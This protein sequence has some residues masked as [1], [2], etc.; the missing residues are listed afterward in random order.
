MTGRPLPGSHGDQPGRRLLRAIPARALAAWRDG[1]RSVRS[2]PGNAFGA[3]FVLALASGAA[4]AVWAVWDRAVEQPLPFP[5]AGELVELV[6]ESAPRG[7]PILYGREVSFLAREASSLSQLGGVQAR[8]ETL[9]REDF[10][11]SVLAGVVDPGVLDLLEV[12]PA[13]GR[14]FRPEDHAAAGSGETPAVLGDPLW[15]ALGSPPGILGAE[16]RLG[17]APLRVIGVMPPRFHFP[18]ASRDLW[19]P[20]PPRSAVGFG[21]VTFESVSAFG[22]LRPGVSPEAAAAEVTALMG[23]TGLPAALE[24]EGVRIGIRRLADRA[25]ATFRPALDLLRAGVWLLALAAAIGAAALRLS[26]GEQRR[27]ALLA[28]HALGASRLD[29]ALAALSRVVLLGSLAA[30]LGAL[31]ARALALLWLPVLELLEIRAPP[32]PAW[33]VAAKGATLAFAAAAAAECAAFRPGRRPRLPGGLVALAAAVA[34]VLAVNATL[35]SRS[36][37]GTLR[38]ANAWPGEN[39]VHLTLDFAAGNPGAESLD[40]LVERLAQLP[41]VAAAGYADVLPDEAGGGRFLRGGSLDGDDSALVVVRR[42]S[43]T[44]LATLGLPIR[45][46]RG[47]LPTDAAPAE[48]VAL[49]DEAVR[50][51]LGGGAVLDR[52]VGPESG[53]EA[54]QFRIVGVI[55]EVRAGGRAEGA[56]YTHY[57]HAA[58]VAAPRVQ[59]AVRLREPPT[60]ALLARLRRL[61]GETDPALRVLRF[62]TAEVRRAARLGVGLLTPVAASVFGVAGVLLGVIGILAQIASDLARKRSE[63]AVRAALGAPE[64]S[65][66]L[67]A[68]HG[69]AGG[70]LLGCLLGLAAAAPLARLLASRLEWVE[71]GGA[72]L[73]LAPFAVCLAASLLGCLVGALLAR[74]ELAPGPARFLT[75]GVDS[76]LSAV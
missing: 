50:R 15:R 31:L 27:G 29:E 25:T 35:L 6:A 11:R 52:I 66:A 20:A 40:L 21:F 33:P 9:A 63:L 39:L 73:Y 2:A 24:R 69:A 65:L 45:D 16:L 37:L 14:L 59:V 53:L 49:A 44:L 48:R 75:R 57:S 26:L 28:R 54:E 8:R 43:P 47:L 72:L 1:F 10:A 64:H 36:A 22:R 23:R 71:P 17:A 51:R 60:E 62:E 38:G 19:L 70:S 7:P 18:D 61:P 76:G 42:V 30:I 41:E 12:A 32:A 56:L 3:V 4:Q 46:G 58:R 34:T 13:L 67:A 55:P 68:A 5:R 74:R